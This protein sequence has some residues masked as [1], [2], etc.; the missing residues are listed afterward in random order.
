[1]AKLVLLFLIAFAAGAQ[2]LSVGVLG[3]AP[4]ND[5]VNGDQINGLQ[6]IAKSPNFTIGGEVQVNLPLNL[7]LE[8]DGLFRPYHFTINSLNIAED[9]TAQQYRFPVLLAYRFKAPLVKPF[10]EAGLSF[11]HLAGISAAVK[12]TI[13]S[14]PGQLLHQSDASFVLGAGIDVKVVLVRVSGELRYTRQSVSNF[15]DFSNLN[16]AEVLVGVHF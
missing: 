13:A 5:V 12:S 4:F 11:D 10:V 3:G 2:S 1:M 6:S 16:Q 9:I 8:V 7:R 15:S 14:G